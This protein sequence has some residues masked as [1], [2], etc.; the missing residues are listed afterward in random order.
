MGRGLASVISAVLCLMAPGPAPELVMTPGSEITARTPSGVITIRAGEKWSR[1]YLWGHCEGSVT[2]WPRKERWY[3]SLGLYWP[4]PGFH[5]PEC[6]GV[7]RAVVEE[8]QQHFDTV[9]AA[10]EWV[11]QRSKAIPYVYRNDGLAVAWQ[12]VIPERKQLNVYVWQL[13]V[14]GKKPTALVGATDAA[15]TTKNLQ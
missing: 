12:T 4:G 11:Q 15:I 9:D 10:L 8:G 2:M 3:G 5:W 13:L 14:A 6:E 1:S 7:A